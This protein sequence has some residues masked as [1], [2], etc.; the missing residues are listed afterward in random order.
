MITSV[1]DLKPTI[2]MVFPTDDE[3]YQHY[4]SYAK[5]RG[6]S[7]RKYRVDW[8]KLDKHVVARYYVCSNQGEK[9]KDKRRKVDYQQCVTKKTHC[10]TL[11][12]I[13]SSNGVWVVDKF[14]KKHNHILVNRNDSF[15]LRSHQKRHKS[16]V[17]LVQRLYKCGIR[18]AHIMRVVKDFAGGEKFA[19]VN[20]H[21]Q[22]TF[23]G[24]G[25]IVDE[26]KESFI[27]LFRTWLR[28]MKNMQPK[29]I[30]TIQDPGIMR[31]IKLVFPLTVHRKYPDLNAVYRSCIYGSNTP[32]EFEERWESMRGES[33][34]IYFQG[35][36]TSAIPLNKF[37]AQFEEAVNKRREKEAKEDAICITLFPSCV[38]GH[39]IEQQAA[40]V[41]TNKVFK[42]FS[43]EWF[44]CFGLQANQCDDEVIAKR[45]KVFHFDGVRENDVQYVLDNH[46]TDITI[47][48]CTLFNN[49]GILC[50]H[51][52]K[53][54]VI[55]DRSYIPDW[56]IMHRCTIAA[57]FSNT[58]SGTLSG[59]SQGQPQ[60]PI[61]LL[62]DLANKFARERS[63]SE[64][65][66]DVALK[67]LNE[68]LVQVQRL[69]ANVPSLSCI[70]E[71]STVVQQTVN[72]LGI[73]SDHTQVSNFS[74]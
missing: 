74:S 62:Q 48:G 41:Y 70:P 12:K 7:V 15:R 53:I 57:Q 50:R 30:F 73:T 65:R 19:G 29:A 1:N 45:Y 40:N 46:Q 5:E 27:W 9:I 54:Y 16:T 38:T 18:Q 11:L 51:I 64:E 3:A 42:F 17:D 10:V 63:L 49:K 44:A 71:S 55:T 31:A 37:V 33:M 21:M 39:R 72:T 58:P 60:Q 66:F 52:L 23:F 35:F 22:C 8:S 34:N 69:Q 26:T 2:G 47:C 28:V 36:F 6:F 68:G 20:H 24:C 14:E 67:I 56:Y 59:L 61:W 32:V 4:N 13:K 43:E 25:L